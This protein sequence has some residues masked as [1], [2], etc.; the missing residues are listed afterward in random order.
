ME[1]KGGKKCDDHNCGIYCACGKMSWG[2]FFVKLFLAVVFIALA[3][4]IALAVCYKLGGG[5]LGAKKHFGLMRGEWGAPTCLSGEKSGGVLMMGGSNVAFKAGKNLTLAIPE[6]VF[7][8]ISK[9][10][11]N[12]IT[13]MNNA[14]QEQ[15]I[16][17]QADTVIFSSS[18]EVGLASLKVGQNIV[19]IGEP[20]KDKKLVAKIINIQ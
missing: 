9:I 7:G 12:Q 4:T 17:S 6:R 15:V 16:L 1:K 5:A 20:D 14:A 19:V 3:L 11:A 8:N 13:V 18:T 10:E 2:H